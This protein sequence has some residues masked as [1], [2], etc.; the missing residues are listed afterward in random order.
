MVGLWVESNLD[1][2]AME[3][4]AP[5]QS[6]SADTRS[7][8]TARLESLLAHRRFVWVVVVLAV[9]LGLPTLDTGLIADDLSQY[10]FLR[11]HHTGQGHGRWWDMF[12][13]IEN[14]PRRTVGMRTSGRYPW[15]VDPE[16]RV[17]FFRPMTVVTHH[18]DHWLWPKT[19]WL[20][21]LHNVAWHAAASAVAWAVARRLVSR[22]AV[23]GIVGVVY[24]LSFSH[25]VPVAWLAHRNGLTSTF[26]ALAAL[27]AHVHWRQGK[28][29]SAG[30]A[31][32]LLLL[33][34]LL[35]AEAGIVAI[36][37]LV[38]YEAFYSSSPLV[39][40]ARA[41]LPA[42][43]CVLVWRM[44]YTGMGYGSY[45]SGGYID[46]VADPVSFLVHMPSRYAALLGV[47]ASAPFIFGFPLGGWIVLTGGVVVIV[48][49]FVVRH[50]EGAARFG[51]LAVLIGC[52]PLTA[53]LPGNRILILTS[54]GSALVFAEILGCWLLTPGGSPL[55]LIAG[56]WVG[57][58][59]VLAPP[60]ASVVLAERLVGLNFEEGAI[61]VYGPDLPDEGL[62]RKGLV[63]LHAPNYP[64]TN[65]L[66][67][68]R[69]TRGLSRPNFLWILHSGEIV[70]TVT[71]IDQRTLELHEPKE[72][73]P[74]G[75]LGSSWR[76]VSRA[77]FEVGDTV[78]TIDYKVTVMEVD[79]DRAIRVQFEFRTHLDHPSF[80]WAD[81]SGDEFIPVDARCLGVQ[82]CVASP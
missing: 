47:S 73:W 57:A 79:E 74:A 26:W 16:I 32:P 5:R 53:S 38:S 30:V 35:S 78:K 76:N 18:V 77:P 17:A 56:V 20:M 36:A 45:A 48:V 31:A 75:V 33:V 55:R 81:W 8:Y 25:A 37:F 52:V 62:D 69:E 4:Y 34:S 11:G 67:D 60:L 7:D 22:P 42:L 6:M 24:V 43:V 40:R 15:W 80:V 66:P 49:I 63:I 59:H 61:H 23:A 2:A 9:L 71:R 19:I 41:L 13:L 82:D 58:V 27:L 70:P 50:G 46:P 14:S 12:V 28:K 54:F 64:S 51:V 10:R 72:G 3:L 21:H 39:E 65:Q 44:V 1:G 29:K 68:V